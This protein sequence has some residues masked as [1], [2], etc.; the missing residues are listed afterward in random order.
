VTRRTVSIASAPGWNARFLADD[1]LEGH[2]IVTLVAWALVEDSDGVTEIVGVVQRGA[3]DEA[4][5][6]RLEFADD[7]EGFDGYAFTGLA[8]RVPDV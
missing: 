6:G 3:T 4:P 1:E 8:T 2:R 5:Q 7:V